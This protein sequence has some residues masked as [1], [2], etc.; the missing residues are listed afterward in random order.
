M[1][2]PV[3]VLESNGCTLQMTSELK[4]NRLASSRKRHDAPFS[5]GNFRIEIT[6]C[7]PALELSV[8]SCGRG[9]KQG[10]SG[11]MGFRVCETHRDNRDMRWVYG[12][13]V[14]ASSCHGCTDQWPDAAPDGDASTKTIG[15]SCCGGCRPSVITFVGRP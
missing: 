8:E 10:V 14:S 1:G 9:G 6:L 12:L 13:I 11:R 7:Q 4:L 2:V 5:I 3:K 15:K